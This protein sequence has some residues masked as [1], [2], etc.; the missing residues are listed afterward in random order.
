MWAAIE[1][2]YR[3]FTFRSRL[4]AKWAVFFDLCGWSWSYEPKDLNGWIPDFAIGER[5][6]LVEVKPYFH[7][8][9]WVDAKRKIVA[10]GCREPVIL[11]GADPIWHANNSSEYGVFGAPEVAKLFAPFVINS[12]DDWETEE[13]HYGFTE[14]NGKIGLCTMDGAWTNQIWIAPDGIS[15]P[16]KWSRVSLGQYESEEHF[17]SKWANACNASRWMKYEG[18]R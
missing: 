1:T 2:V 6:R 13:L 8:S 4:E 7:A 14:G 18:K 5:A 16:N 15:H 11:L 17:A 3:N 12:Q 10:S 9:E